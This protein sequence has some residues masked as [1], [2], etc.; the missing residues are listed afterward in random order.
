M[1]HVTLT[2]A[3]RDAVEALRRDPSLRPAE[4]DR[5]EMVLLSASGCSVPCIAAHFACCSAT[6]RRLVHRFTPDNLR[7]L[8]RQPPGPAPDWAHRQ[9]I[10]QALDR[11]LAQER[12]WTAAQLAQAL[13]ADGLRLSARQVRRYLQ[14]GH[15]RWRRTVRSLHHKQDPARVAAAKAEL[16]ALKRGLRRAS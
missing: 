4:R 15:A 9:Q 5:V 10:G 6:V 3:Q 16:V 2:S 13:A 7:S 8:R 14:L 12:T 11:L 1:L